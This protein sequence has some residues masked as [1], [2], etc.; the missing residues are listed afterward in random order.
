MKG[1]DLIA[2]NIN[3]K[4]GFCS[5]FAI[6]LGAFYKLCP[7]LLQRVMNSKPPNY[8]EYI[9]NFHVMTHSSRRVSNCK[10]HKVSVVILNLVSNVSL[11]L[12]IISSCLVLDNMHKLETETEI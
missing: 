7:K 8:V 3:R 1:P 10:L 12:R 11:F 4:T 6:F 5:L 2:K 9:D